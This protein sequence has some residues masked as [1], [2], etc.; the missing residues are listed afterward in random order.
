MY[1]GEKTQYTNIS[2]VNISDVVIENYAA[3]M[4]FSLYNLDESRPELL[5]A[6][7]GCCSFQTYDF[8]R[9]RLIISFEFTT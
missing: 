5:F 2:G 6:Y 7:L 9:Y 4:I 3:E 8:N 1:D